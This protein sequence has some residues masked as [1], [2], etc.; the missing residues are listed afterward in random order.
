MTWIDY[1]LLI[2]LAY[3][4]FKGARRGFVATIGAFIGILLGAWAAGH[5]YESVAQWLIEFWDFSIMFAIVCAFVGLYLV[6]N[7][8]MTLIIR[9]ATMVLHVL[10]LGKTM[11]KLIGAV[12][13]LAEGLLLIGLIIWVVTLFPFDNAFTRTLNTSPV[14]R[15]FESTTRIVRPLLPKSLRDVDF[16]YLKDLQNLTDEKAQYLQQHMPAFI[17][18]IIE[19]SDQLKQQAQDLKDIAD[20]KDIEQPPQ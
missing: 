10:P 2:A 13:G 18:K 7:I 17:E 15:F 20:E 14:A 8:V 19:R 9:V 12:L 3:F 6:V 4:I 11:N 16:N 5:Y 1:L